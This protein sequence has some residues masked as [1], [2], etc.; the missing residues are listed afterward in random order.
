MSKK[1]PTDFLL[2]VDET[3]Y[4]GNKDFMTSGKIRDFIKCPLM[5][6]KKINGLIEKAESDDMNFGKALHVMTLERETFD[7]RY[8]VS[9]GPI[10]PGTQNPYGRDTKKF[11]EWA[12]AQTGGREILTTAEH[13]IL[14]E[15][16]EMIV[17][18]WGAAEL[19]NGP[20]V[21]EGTAYAEVDGFDCQIRTDWFSGE[22]GIVDLKTCRDIDRIKWDIQEHRYDLQMAFYAIVVSKNIREKVPVHMI[23]VEK[24]EPYRSMV[25]EIPEGV[26]AP[27]VSLIHGALER[28]RECMTKKKWPTGCE[29]IHIYQPYQY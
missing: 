10:N 22:H 7:K 3:E 20:G 27:A 13:A 12:A 17:C 29:G 11:L 21:A 19:L 16:Y 8:L 23:F 18:N 9:D 4:H 28:L 14:M 1:Y 25:L 5:Y 15:M 2:S 6:Y 24:Q 26:L